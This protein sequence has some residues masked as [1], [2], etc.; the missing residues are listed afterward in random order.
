MF[1][2]VFSFWSLDMFIGLFAFLISENCMSDHLEKQFLTF[3]QGIIHISSSAGL[4][5]LVSALV[6]IWCGTVHHMNPV[7]VKWSCIV[8][9]NY[10]SNAGPSY[11]IV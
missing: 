11:F 6:S 5:R 3:S 9:N 8:Y 2:Y 7:A 4:V 10:E 1:S